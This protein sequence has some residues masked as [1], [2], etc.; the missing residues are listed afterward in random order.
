MKNSIKREQSQ[1]CLNF[2]ERKNFRLQAKH[3]I[4]M[5]L[6]LLM[7]VA[8][9]AW[10]DIAVGNVFKTGSTIDFGTS[11]VRYK[12]FSGSSD[13]SSMG[14]SGMVTLTYEEYSNGKHKFCFP[15]GS[16]AQ[17]MYIVSDNN[18]EPWGIRVSGGEGTMGNPYSF[19]VLFE[20][21]VSLS[22]NNNKDEATFAMPA[23][24]ATVGFDIVRD[25]SEQMTTK[26][27]DAADGADYRIRLRKDGTAWE[28]ADM[29]VPQLMALITVHDAIEDKDLTYYSETGPVDCT[30][31]IFAID[32]NDQPIGDAISFA[33]LEPGRYKAKAVA[34]ADG[35][36]IGETALSN[37][38]VLFQGYEVEVP[39][40]EMITYYKDEPLKEEEEDI[41]LYTISSVSD[42]KATLSNKSDAMPSNTPMLVYNNSDETKVILL[43]PCNEPDLAITVA[44]EFK[45]TNEDKAQGATGNGP[46]NMAEDTKYYGCNGNDFVW[47]KNADDVAAHRCWIEISTANAPSR[48]TIVFEKE[49]ATGVNEVSEV[50]EVSDDSW[51]DL[52]GRKLDGEPTAKGVY[53][54]DGKKV[55]VR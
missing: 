37:V 6:V 3:K 48:L 25:M 8:S 14:I 13:N 10:A 51:Y 20:E 15:T 27:G 4:L 19:E 52:S 38:I 22:I 55:V 16:G 46:W 42:G 26:V 28:L 50:N 47:I 11:S 54:K 31:Q 9:G 53:I 23:Y 30:L 2:A 33:N 24:D 49:E 41:E 29:T 36:Y 32:D 5:T 44:P 21:Q 35:D 40:K 7:T 1:A 39:A 12:Q 43:I 34:K 45:G 18:A 17:F